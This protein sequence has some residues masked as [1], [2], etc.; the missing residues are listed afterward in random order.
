MEIL[1]GQVR[2]PGYP[3]CECTYAKMDNGQLYYFIKDGELSNQNIIVTTIL[4][5]A[6]GHTPYTSLGLIN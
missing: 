4:K 6:I 2:D 1:K 3:D 5:E